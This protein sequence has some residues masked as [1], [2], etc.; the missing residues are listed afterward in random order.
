[1]LTSG[2]RQSA[3][4]GYAALPDTVIARERQVLDKIR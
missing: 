3:A 2:Q 4:L 1:M